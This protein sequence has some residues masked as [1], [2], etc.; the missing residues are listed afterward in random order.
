MSKPCCANCIEFDLGCPSTNLLGTC[1][2]WV[3]DAVSSK[4]SLPAK[5]SS[6]CEAA[7]LKDSMDNEMFYHY[8]PMFHSLTA[9]LAYEETRGA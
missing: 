8:Y 2:S 4:H 1:P 3:E 7:K 5:H 9:L 6:V